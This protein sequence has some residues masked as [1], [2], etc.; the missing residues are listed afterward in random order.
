MSAMH[1]LAFLTLMVV[2][3]SEPVL[4]QQTRDWVTVS[5]ALIAII[6]ACIAAWLAQMGL[7]Q[8]RQNATVAAATG[9]EL[10]KV[11]EDSSTLIEKTGEIHT[12]VN[13]NLSEVRAELK[14]SN[15]TIAGLNIAQAES[16][17]RMA[18]ME[19]LIRSLVPE[20]GKQSPS[21]INGEKLDTLK[22]M[23]TEVQS[24]T[25]PIPV[26]DE[27]VLAELKNVVNTKLDVIQESVEHPVDKKEES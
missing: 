4:V 8:A 16:A 12:Q 25:P 13:S 22:T 5:L 15:E 14:V 17:K 7:S 21:Q 9:V 18:S 10:R 2:L 23:L 6:P 11:K 20:K 1:T 26:K 24:G 19:E 27:A 3:Q